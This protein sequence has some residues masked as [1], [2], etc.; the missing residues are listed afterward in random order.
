MQRFYNDHSSH[1]KI[2]TFIIATLLVDSIGPYTSNM[3][4][5]LNIIGHW[6]HIE[7]E[8]S[9]IVDIKMYSVSYSLYI[10]QLELQSLSTIEKAL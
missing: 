7:K 5:Y 6:G 9:F 2:N 8:E 10:E 4:A 3:G 1:K